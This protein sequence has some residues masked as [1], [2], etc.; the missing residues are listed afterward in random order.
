MIIGYTSARIATVEHLSFSTSHTLTLSLALSHS[1]A[2]TLTLPGRLSHSG[3]QSQATHPLASRQSNI[4]HTR[5]HALNPSLTP[6]HSHTLTLTPSHSHTLTLSHSH[7]LTLSHSHTL[8]LAHTP[9]QVGAQWRTITGYTSA[10]IATFEH[11]PLSRS[12]PLTLTLTHSR[13]HALTLSHRHTLTLLHAPGQVGSQWRTITGYT[14]ARI[15]TVEH[16]TLSISL[17]LPHT[18]TLSH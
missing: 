8:T 14:S 9:G 7:T 17:A 10:R 1:H 3:G 18:R 15:A 4:S 13:P 5:S 16:F 12:H 6:S 2:H 11:F